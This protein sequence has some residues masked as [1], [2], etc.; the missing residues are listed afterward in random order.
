MSGSKFS[1]FDMDFTQIQCCFFTISFFF[2]SK[3]SIS[4]FYSSYHDLRFSGSLLCLN[5][6][7]GRQSFTF[8]TG[9]FTDGH[10]RLKKK[11]KRKAQKN[12]QEKQKKDK[13]TD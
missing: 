4:N 5:L 10:M 2:I 12:R 8:F 9:T 13:K 3:S 1:N 7:S 6:T 11:N